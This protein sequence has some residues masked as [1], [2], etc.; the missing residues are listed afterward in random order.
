MPTYPDVS[1]S[2][3]PSN[4]ASHLGLTYSEIDLSSELDLGQ[5]EDR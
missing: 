5:Q 1:S 4:S 2:L 3:L